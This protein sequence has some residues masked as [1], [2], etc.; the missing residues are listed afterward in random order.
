MAK[1]YL[2]AG[3]TKRAVSEDCRK[4]FKAA[5]EKVEKNLNYSFLKKA[6][7]ERKKIESKKNEKR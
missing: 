2:R 4:Y 1:K 7:I 3:Y 5:Y 6:F